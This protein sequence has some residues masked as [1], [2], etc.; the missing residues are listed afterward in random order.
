[1]IK[2]ERSAVFLNDFVE[3]NFP[4]PSSP[5]LSL[6]STYLSVVFEW[7]YEVREGEMGEGREEKKTLKV[8]KKPK[9]QAN[10]VFEAIN[11]HKSCKWLSVYVWW[12]KFALT[13]NMNWILFFIF[14][15]FD[16]LCLEHISSRRLASLH[17]IFVKWFFSRSFN[18]RKQKIRES[19]LVDIHFFDILVLPRF[20]ETIVLLLFYSCFLFARHKK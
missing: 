8:E 3:P 5:S 12:W 9:I 18:P 1:M 11:E 17:V 19:S 13:M 6:P 20:D 16:N 14:Y 10:H 2:C 15:F 4:P 7:I